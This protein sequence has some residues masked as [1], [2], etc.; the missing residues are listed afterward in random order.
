MLTKTIEYIKHTAVYYQ[1]YEVKQ[2]TIYAEK[3]A[4]G[5]GGNIS[6]EQASAVLNNM[7]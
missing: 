5:G 6:E 3:I 7:L 1:P 2:I 4:W